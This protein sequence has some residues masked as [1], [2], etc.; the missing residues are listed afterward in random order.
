M[1]LVYVPEEHVA[2]L[3]LAPELEGQ[4]VRLGLVPQ[5]REV[6][7][8]L[9]VHVVQPLVLVVPEGLAAEGQVLQFLQ[10]YVL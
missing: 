10:V 3:D 8:V 4:V 6:V 1:D 7:L 2:V 9:V 5:L